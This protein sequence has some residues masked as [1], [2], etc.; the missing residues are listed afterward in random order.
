MYPG[1]LVDVSKSSH[2]SNKRTYSITRI[3]R[4]ATTFFH[5]LPFAS[6]LGSYARNLG[7]RRRAPR[8][9]RLMKKGASFVGRGF[10]RGINTL[11]SSGVLTPKEIKDVFF[12]R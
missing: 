12:S 8:L 3:C 6:G 1:S 5:N 4:R 9:N 2:K 7:F 10:S 11:F